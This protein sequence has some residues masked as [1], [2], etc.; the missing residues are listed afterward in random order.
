MKLVKRLFKAGLTVA[1]VL[2]GLKLVTSM[3]QI[4]RD[5]IRYS[6]GPKV[7]MLTNLEENHGGTGFLVKVP[8]GAT[9]MVTNRHVCALAKEGPMKAIFQ[10]GRKRI[11]YPKRLGLVADLCVASVPK[12]IHIEGLEVA[13]HLRVGQMLNIVGHPKLMPLTVSDGGEF[14]GKGKVNVAFNQGP[15]AK[16]GGMFHTE[17]DFFGTLCI[18]TVTAGFTNVQALPG[19]SGSPVLDNSGRVVGVLFAGAE[20]D[21]GCI[22]TLDQLQGILKGL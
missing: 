14:I 5:Y 9:V 22:M 13:D 3:P 20:D 19:N 2:M 12:D 17:S 4:H 16:E 8:S 11:V 1:I 6:V 10:D 7:V 18:M 21:W 15:C